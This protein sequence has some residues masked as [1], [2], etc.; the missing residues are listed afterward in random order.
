M[1]DD[2]ILNPRGYELQNLIGEG[3]Y[4]KVRAAYRYVFLKQSKDTATV[5]FSTK[6][7]SKCAIKCIDKRN[8]PDDFVKKF[9]PRELEI[10]PRLNHQNIVKVKSILQLSLRVPPSVLGRF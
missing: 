4:S 6:I 8:A 9:L 10:L 7:N 1:T 2:D 3:A 5:T